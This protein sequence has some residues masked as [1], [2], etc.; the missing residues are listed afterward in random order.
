MF[1]RDTW[2][3]RSGVVSSNNGM[4]LTR[5]TLRRSLRYLER[6]DVGRLRREAGRGEIELAPEP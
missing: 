2:R 4:N 5:P 1:S 6:V 3:L